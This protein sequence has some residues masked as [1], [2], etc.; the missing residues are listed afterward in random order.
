ML[1][2]GFLIDS[3]ATFFL[4]N[5]YLV[6]AANGCQVR[7]KNEHYLNFVFQFSKKQ[8]KKLKILKK[9]KKIKIFKF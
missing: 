9:F 4:I 6:T 3:I 8:I 7:S 5:L 1:F 2:F